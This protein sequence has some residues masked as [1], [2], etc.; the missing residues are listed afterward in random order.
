MFKTITEII[1]FSAASLTTIAYL[2]QVIKTIRLKKTAEI[3]LLMYVLFCMGLFGWLVYGLIIV[4]LPLIMANAISLS[5]ALIILFLKIR[6][7]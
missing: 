4:N 1:G 2:P 5:L 6:H 7:G 3:S